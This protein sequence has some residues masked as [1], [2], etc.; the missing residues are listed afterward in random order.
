MS[1]AK[2]DELPVDDYCATMYD[3]LTELE[4]DRLNILESILRQKEVMSRAYNCR[5]KI[6]TFNVGNLI[7]KT[8]LHI[9]KK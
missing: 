3:E 9:D 5:L 2:W 7:W 6:R 1:M 4:N 8:T